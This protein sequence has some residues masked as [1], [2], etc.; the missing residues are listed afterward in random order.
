MTTESS[1]IVTRGMEKDK[2]SLLSSVIKDILQDK[3]FLELIETHVESRLSDMRKSI[4][5]QE[6]RI[7]DLEIAD[8]RKQHEIKH[9]QVTVEQQTNQIQDLSWKLD[10]QEQYSRRNCLLFFGHDESADENT[11]DVI[12][13]L[14]KEKLQVDLT[15]NDIER[16][17]R[18]GSK[19]KHKS[20]NTPRPIIAKFNTYRKRQE[21][22]SAR[23]KLAGTRKSIQEDLTKRNQELLKYVQVSRKVKSSWTRDGRVLILDQQNRKHLI[24][25]KHD[26]DTLKV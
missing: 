6:G 22:I 11:D 25:N 13:Q 9:L 18:T 1:S 20:T 4:E 10:Q 12:L 15:R 23:R 8:D 5:K 2:A 7:F 16:S 3:R 24:K 19:S 26:L 17:H 14:A 21:V